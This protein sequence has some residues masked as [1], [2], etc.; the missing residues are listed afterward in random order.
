MLERS[1]KMRVTTHALVPGLKWR[2][3]ARGRF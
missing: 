3:K 1:G 2:G